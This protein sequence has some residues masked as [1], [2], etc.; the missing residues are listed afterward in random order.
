MT[1]PPAEPDPSANTESA[2]EPAEAPF[3]APGGAVAPGAATPESTWAAAA[4][5][6]VVP[7]QN[8]DPSKRSRRGWIIG[9]VVAVAVL[10]LAGGG[11]AA[12]GFISGGGAQPEEVVPAEAVAFVKIDLDP[13]ASQKVALARLAARFDVGDAAAS[14]D[15]QGPSQILS[16]VLSEATDV[17]VDF[18]RDI[19]PWVGSR[20]AVALIAPEDGNLE[21]AK[22][23]VVIASTDDQ[24]AQASLERL[25]PATDGYDVAVRNGFALVGS[26]NDVAA[27]AQ[28]LSEVSAFTQA[29]AAI[30][31]SIVLGY[32]DLD[33]IVDAAEKAGEDTSDLPLPDVVSPI[34]RRAVSFGV[35]AEP[36]SISVR[37]RLYGLTQASASTTAPL[38][39]NEGSVALLGIRGLS[40]TITKAAEE[41]GAD[42]GAASLIDPAQ[43]ASALGDLAEFQVA[44]DSAND[45]VFQATVVSS[46]VSATE[47]FWQSLAGFGGLTVSTE[48]N[49]VTIAEPDAAGEF[50]PTTSLDPIT[51]LLPNAATANVVLWADV[52]ALESG[53]TGDDL[54]ARAR[55]LKAVGL[56]VSTATE[57]DAEILGVAQF[58]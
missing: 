25:F 32:V 44:L 42:A 17:D 58:D 38:T 40:D 19:E 54:D 43:F 50:G 33:G 35:V 1:T 23:L 39:L 14:A 51:S 22:P 21:E 6:D 27:P 47:A 4:P 20:A 49:Q 30:G 52:N 18:A 13:A 45:P 53:S 29:E 56:S 5:Q 24:A 41:A 46:D 16:D 9:S 7:G 31:D 8:A 10:I 48:G 2:G 26:P 55:E 11:F 3:V 28:S 34:G 37:G 15:D 57:G 36:D 12:Y